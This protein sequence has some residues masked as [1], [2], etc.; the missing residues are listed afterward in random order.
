MTDQDLVKPVAVF[1]DML[2]PEPVNRMWVDVLTMLYDLT[3]T[4]GCDT[5]RRGYCLQHAWYESDPPCPQGRVRDL[6]ARVGLEP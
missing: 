4:T 3:E 2:I 5:D 1:R 6:L